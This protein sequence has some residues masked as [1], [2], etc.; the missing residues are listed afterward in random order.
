VNLSD[1]VK[2][3]LAGGWSYFKFH[4]GLTKEYVPG[5]QTHGNKRNVPPGG[6][7]ELIEASKHALK[8]WVQF[9]VLLALVVNINTLF[10]LFH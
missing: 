5:N 7:A 6:L 8:I 1:S 3:L 9:V 2:P 4:I 10:S